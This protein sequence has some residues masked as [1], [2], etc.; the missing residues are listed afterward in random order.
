[1]TLH[2]APLL[3]CTKFGLQGISC[4]LVWWRTT[5][6]RSIVIFPQTVPCNC[7][8]IKDNTG[9]VL[10]WQCWHHLRKSW[11]AQGIGNP[12]KDS[13]TWNPESTGW[14]PESKTVLDYLTWG[15]NVQF[16]L[17]IVK[18]AAVKNWAFKG[19][20]R[21]RVQGVRTPPWDDLRFSSTT[22]ILPK[23]KKKKKTTWFIGFEVDQETSAPPPKKN[24][25]SA[26]EC[27]HSDNFLTRKTARRQKSLDWLNIRTELFF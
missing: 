19:R 27:N 7:I 4:N 15:V 22:S 18:L 12:N 26:P 20:S 13:S 1:M 23:K 9:L 5:N 11:T 10:V 17:S 21:G 16:S 25:G 3:F 14:N 8:M 6:H 2:A 24:P